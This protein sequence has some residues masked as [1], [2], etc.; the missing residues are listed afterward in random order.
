M[1][2]CRTKDSLQKK[3]ICGLV[4]SPLPAPPWLSCIGIFMPQYIFLYYVLHLPH[5][6]NPAA[7][8][9]CVLHAAQTSLC[10]GWIPLMP[11]VASFS[12]PFT[13][14]LLLLR[15]ALTQTVW[16]VPFRLLSLRFFSPVSCGRWLLSLFLLFFFPFL[17]FFFLFNC[18][19][20]FVAWISLWSAVEYLKYVSH[21]IC[22]FLSH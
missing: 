19:L 1:K 11:F 6:W 16:S 21:H 2:V 20:G 7:T 15:M 22:V 18:N 8:W 3:W 13:T 17:S 4:V 14:C 12:P 9:Q 5:P 10:V